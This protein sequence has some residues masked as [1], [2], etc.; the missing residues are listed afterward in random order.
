MEQ[1]VEIRGKEV[2]LN[3]P[4]DLLICCSCCSRDESPPLEF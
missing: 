3:K 2:D 4:F 1:D